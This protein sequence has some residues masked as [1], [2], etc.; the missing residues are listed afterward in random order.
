MPGKGKILLMDDE[1]VI[2]E[3][4]QDVLKFLGY[5]VMFAEE[6]SEAVVLY[7]QEKA[8]G[9]PFDVVILDLLVVKG[10]GGKETVD[11]LLK[12]DPAVKA[13]VS[14]GFIN[15]PVVENFTRYGFCERLTKPYSVTD[16][17]NLLEKVMK[18]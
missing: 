11:Q 10:L 16:L 6:G 9:V 15:D 4:T 5:D 12:F 13:V 3:M 18:N 8:A 7:K 17:K 2:R 1:L 14:S